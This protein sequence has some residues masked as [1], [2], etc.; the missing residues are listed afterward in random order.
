MSGSTAA[1]GT[2]DQP[3]KG[4]TPWAHA[5]VLGAVCALVI[6]VYALSAHSGRLELE[7]S[8]APDT[9][10]NL[11]V[12]GFRSGQLNLIREA[13]PGLVQLPDPYDPVANRGYRESTG[14]W[15][16]DTSYYKGKL[17]L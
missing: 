13:P 4:R 16:E 8:G 1:G 14:Q 6:G 10:Y 12:R 2:A 11:L 5:A 7:S 3:P 17:Y 9:Y 15:L